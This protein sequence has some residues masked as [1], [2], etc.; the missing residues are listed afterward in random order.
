MC[1]L[2]GVELILVLGFI[3]KRDRRKIE[4]VSSVLSVKVKSVVNLDL[5]VEWLP[6]S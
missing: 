1:F 4:K 2:R 3:E 6:R 5:G